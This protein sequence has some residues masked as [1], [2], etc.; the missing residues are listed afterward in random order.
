M[1]T[2]EHRESRRLNIFIQVCGLLTV[3]LGC[4]AILGWI[5]DS[6]Q[7]ASFGPNIIPMALSTAVLFVAFGLIIFYH[8]RLPSSRIVSWAGIAF[9]SVGTL[10]A[11]LLLYYSLNG[12]LLDAEHLGTKM[13]RVVDGFVVGHMSPVTAFCFVLVG[14]S[15]LIMLTKTAQNKQLKTSLIF[16]ALVFFIS[17]II[18]L[19]YLF[20][21]PLLYGGSFIPPALTTSIAFLFL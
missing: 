9:S 19:S 12:I 1:R 3:S 13:N 8:N 5:F 6:T 20:G 17:I 4:S 11:S 21:A 14:L 10:A 7:L 15:V 2:N 16:A 18:L